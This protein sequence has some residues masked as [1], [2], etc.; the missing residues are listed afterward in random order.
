MRFGP[1][2]HRTAAAGPTAGPSVALQE[3]EKIR[4]KHIN[5]PERKHVSKDDEQSQLG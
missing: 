5:K 4:T 1:V 3:P 2:A